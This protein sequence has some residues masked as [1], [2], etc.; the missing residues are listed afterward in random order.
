M[1][2]RVFLLIKKIYT[3]IAS[4]TT[5]NYCLR[6]IFLNSNHDHIGYACYNYLLCHFNLGMDWILLV[7]VKFKSYKRSISRNFLEKLHTLTSKRH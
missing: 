1:L 5:T 2:Q 7:K 3:A 4:K 6:T